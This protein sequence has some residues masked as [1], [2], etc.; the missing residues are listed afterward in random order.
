MEEKVSELEKWHLNF[1]AEQKLHFKKQGKKFSKKLD[2]Q[3]ESIDAEIKEFATSMQEQMCNNQ[4][5]IQRMMQEQKEYIDE[6]LKT[7]MRSIQHCMSSTTKHSL[8]IDTLQQSISPTEGPNTKRPK[9]GNNGFVTANVMEDV[10]TLKQNR[11]DQAS[12]TQ[13]AWA[14]GNVP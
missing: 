5:D 3:T 1:D 4:Y 12:D 9:H 10:D 11:G 6:H 14:T 8:Q 2:A 13:E 7:L